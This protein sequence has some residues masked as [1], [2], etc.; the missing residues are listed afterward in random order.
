MSGEWHGKTT[1]GHDPTGKT[2][3]ILGMGGIGRVRHVP[4]HVCKLSDRDL[5]SCPSRTRIR[6]EHHLPQPQQVVS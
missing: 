5:G 4:P 6:N 2:L 1:L 3:G